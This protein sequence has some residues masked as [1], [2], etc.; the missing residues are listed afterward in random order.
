MLVKLREEHHPTRLAKRSHWLMN[1]D[2]NVTIFLHTRTCTP[3]VCCI[4]ESVEGVSDSFLLIL[5]DGVP[6]AELLLTTAV[7]LRSQVKLHNND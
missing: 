7:M 6:P 1:N 5:D 4:L 2:S 3:F